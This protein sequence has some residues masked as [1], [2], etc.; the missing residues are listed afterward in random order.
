MILKPITAVTA[1]AIEHAL[2]CARYRACIKGV[3][4]VSPCRFTQ[5]S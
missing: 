3:S 5:L 4:A 1:A 2:A